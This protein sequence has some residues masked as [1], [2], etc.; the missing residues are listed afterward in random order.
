M[1]CP[2]ALTKLNTTNKKQFNEN[3]NQVEEGSPQQNHP[4]GTTRNSKGGTSKIE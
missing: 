2:D 3:Y 1:I 4:Q